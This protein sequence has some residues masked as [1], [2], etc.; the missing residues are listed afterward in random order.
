LLTST[1]TSPPL[2]S[3]GATRP[4]RIA[5]WVKS[6]PALY[7]TF[8]A[9]Q[10][11]GL[12]RMGHEVHVIAARP[13]A[14][15]GAVEN[16]AA[17]ASVQYRRDIPNT[18]SRRLLSALQLAA[19]ASFGG[20]TVAR[21]T[22]RGCRAAFGKR[23]LRLLFESEPFFRRSE[24]D[25]IHCQ[26]GPLGA[27]AVELRAAHVLQGPIVTAVRGYDMSI[28]ENRPAPFQ[29][30]FRE[31]DLFLP[32]CGAFCERLTRL[33]CEAS[34]IVVHRSGIDC[35]RI[36]AAAEGVRRSSAPTVV[37]VARLVEK[38]GI[39]DALRAVA[40]VRSQLRDLRYVI[41]GDGPLRARL[42]Q[43]A[44]ELDL[45]DAVQFTGALEHSDAIARIAA[46]HAFVLP[47]V[48]AADGAQ[49]GIPNALKEAMLLG[50]PVVATRHAGIPEL[51]EDGVSGYLVA[52]HDVNALAERLACLLTEPAKAA[53]T[54]GAGRQ[55]V[56]ETYDSEQLNQK[57]VGLYRRLAAAK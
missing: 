1:A 57:L 35:S 13:H 56:S 10:I 22:L 54:G 15:S 50:V 21:Q 32:V 37:T 6:F 43:L 17:P 34:R 42:E 18:R 39:D 52:E 27:V 47:S 36:R 25:V 44:R 23:E 4:L 38:K 24:F 20:R 14:H 8:I 51:I 55:F 11:H 46:A 3:A 29:R 40:K 48:T 45:L 28:M 49:E 41:V 5:V 26:Y 33:G 16:H 30:F 19:V 2:P 53:Q 31:G 12:V 7:E 9:N